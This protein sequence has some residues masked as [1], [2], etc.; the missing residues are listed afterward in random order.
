MGLRAKMARRAVQG[1]AGLPLTTLVAALAVRERQAKVLLVAQV[2]SGA[3][4][5]AEAAARVAWVVMLLVIP[6][7]M[8]ALASPHQSLGLLFFM[9]VAV[10]AL[11]IT[12]TKLVQVAVVAAVTAPATTKQ[13]GPMEPQTLAVAVAVAVIMLRAALVVQGL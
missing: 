5:A 4:A 11:H 3:G 9:A 10:A 12:I 13:T 1:A 2:L 6:Q 8:A 7:G